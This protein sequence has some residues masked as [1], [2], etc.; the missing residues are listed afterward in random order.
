MFANSF[1]LRLHTRQVDI[2]SDLKYDRIAE[3][4]IC[5]TLAMDLLTLAI[6]T[7][8]VNRYK[9]LGLFVLD[10]MYYLFVMLMQL[11]IFSTDFNNALGLIAALCGWIGATAISYYEFLQF[12]A[13]MKAVKP[14]CTYIAEGP[15]MIIIIGVFLNG[16]LLFLA[17]C[18]PYIQ[19]PAILSSLT[20][21][22]LT[23]CII[24]IPR[25]IS[26]FWILH[27]VKD[28][29][30]IT[31][32]VVRRLGKNYIKISGIQ[33]INGIV[34]LVMMF[35]SVRDDGR[36]VSLV[37][38]IVEILLYYSICYMLA[39]DISDDT[40]YDRLGE[41]LLVL[42]LAM[43]LLTLVTT[44]TRSNRYKALGLFILDNM[45][46][47]F[48]M[49]IHFKVFSDDLNNFL[50]LVAAVCGWL[51]ATALSYE[52]VQFSAIMKAVR[53]N[54]SYI[55]EGPRI[56]ITIGVFLSGVLLVLDYSTAYVNLPGIFSD[57]T[58]VNLVQCI[59]CIPRLLSTFWILYAVNDIAKI[60]DGVVRKLGKNYIKISGIQIVNGLV[61]L[62]LLHPSIQ[63][64]D[65]LV[66]L[67]GS[68]VEI[69]LY[70]SI[71]HML[72]SD[73]SNGKSTTEFTSNVQK[74]P[75]DFTSTHYKSP[76]VYF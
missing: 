29:A 44:S 56:I 34:G 24:C 8:R 27:V 54:Y 26:T 35:P 13:I 46:Y 37:G 4:V 21:V 1:T 51:G 49:L 6:T 68:I 53:P 59:V 33:I 22:N 17:F 66:S 5:L 63:Q 73:L 23:Q 16:L 47:F 3:F 55:A 15:R 60:T 36:F 40:A 64:D 19:L 61:G 11:N 7:T 67:V 70:Y 20:L 10:N 2:E 30:Q 14:S 72:S 48:V 75:S 45:Y 69:L 12:I 25:L 31:D 57:L 42:T 62:V 39:A 41:F 43:D 50:G 9:S 76:S 74:H 18:S 58:L 38:S 52:F 28:I 32:G 71:A 65:R